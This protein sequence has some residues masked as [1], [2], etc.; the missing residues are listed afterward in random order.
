M[1]LARKVR[2]YPTAEQ[3]KK[4]YQHYGGMKFIYNWGLGKNIEYYKETGKAKSAAT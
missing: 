4:M 3:E 1:K 2:L